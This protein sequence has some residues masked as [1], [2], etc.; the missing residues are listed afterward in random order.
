MAAKVSKNQTRGQ[1]SQS[2]NCRCGGKI[3]M[4]TV[5]QSGKMRHFAQCTGSCGKTARK[6]RDLM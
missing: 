5:M 3:E 1:R 6:P 2:L 4:R